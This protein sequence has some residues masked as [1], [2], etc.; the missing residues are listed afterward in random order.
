MKMGINKAN[1]FSKRCRHYNYLQIL[2]SKVVVFPYFD[3]ASI[4]SRHVWLLSPSGGAQ[5]RS[6]DTIRLLYNMSVGWPLWAGGVILPTMRKIQEAEK[7]ETR[8]KH[9]KTVKTKL[10]LIVYSHHPKHA[11]TNCFNF[12]RFKTEI[13]VILFSPFLPLPNKTQTLDPWV[14]APLAA[15]RADRMS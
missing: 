7:T 14:L 2:L 10:V 3:F 6:E 5:L 11:Q 13:I 1:G 8:A 4:A 12:L 15:K 9:N